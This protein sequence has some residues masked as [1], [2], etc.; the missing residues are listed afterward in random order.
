M[1]FFY[2]LGIR[3]YT[4]AIHL[5]AWFNPKARLM[6]Q[7]RRRTFGQ[8]AAAFAG[9]AQ[10]VAWFHC[11]SLGE[12]EQAR[13]VLEV[14]KQQY[15]QWQVLLTFF[16]PS[17][18]EAQKG[19]PLAQAVAYL[20]AD[21]PSHARRLL[22]LARPQVA[23]FVKYEFWHFYTRELARRKIPLVSF[24]ALF[25]PGQVYFKLWG[26]FYRRILARFAH[27]F[28]QNPESQQLLA[29]LGLPQ[30]SLA[31]DTRFD[32][33]LALDR[34]RQPV[35]VAA[36]FQAGQPLLVLG[37]TWREDI[38][39]VAPVLAANPT[40][41]AIIAPHEV[42]PAELDWTEQ[43]LAPCPVVRYT[44]A[45]AEPD[46]ASF[47][48]L[49]VDNV[50]LLSRLYQYARV[51]YV[52]GSF[53]PK[54]ASTWVGGVLKTGVHNVLEAAVYGVPVLFG[55]QAYQGTTEAVELVAEGGAFPVANPT[56]LAQCIQR[57]WEQPAAHAQAGAA[58]AAYVRDQAG[59]VEVVMAYCRQLLG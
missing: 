44:R 21:S 51:A 45:E 41:R 11:A 24:S 55:S 59:A 3:L 20:P 36:R 30:V 9:N 34:Q 58:A 53:L 48:V 43:R 27:I 5:A 18:A 40:W 7:G 10:P 26:G 42:Y 15:P 6:V 35:P 31:G 47:Q 57:F 46:L 38:E 23:F 50:G 4:W 54:A 37:S 19:Y 17:G 1:L 14:F 22:D 2:W 28:V 32:R 16:S 8:L 29:R 25:R 13:P 12:F 33:V 56:E 39:V 52:G 49:L